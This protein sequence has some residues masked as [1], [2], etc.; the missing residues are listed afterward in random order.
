MV[1]VVLDY[2][3]VF[4]PAEDIRNGGEIKCDLEEKVKNVNLEFSRVMASR[5]R[6]AL[7]LEEDDA[8]SVL[9]ADSLRL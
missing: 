5:T 7:L 6:K 8:C 4:I 1:I 2:R 3:E 9:R